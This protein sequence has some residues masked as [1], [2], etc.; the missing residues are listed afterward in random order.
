M[1]NE[2]KLWNEYLLAMEAHQKSMSH[3]SLLHKE[4][5]LLAFREAF[6]K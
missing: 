1:K 3:I 5:A 6:T 2:E 4:A